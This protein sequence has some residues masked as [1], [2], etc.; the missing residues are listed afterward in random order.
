MKMPYHKELI[1]PLF[2]ALKQLGGSGTVDEIYEKVIENEKIPEKILSVMQVDGGNQTKVAYN[3]AWARTKLKNCGIITNPSRALWVI[4][5]EY[6]NTDSAE[7]MKIADSFHYTKNKDPENKTNTVIKNDLLEEYKPWEERLQEILLEINPYSFEVL[8]QRMLRECGLTQVEVTKKSGDGGIDG[9]GTLKLNGIIGF[10]LAFQCKRYKNS[11]SSSEIRD[12]RGSMTA[13]TEKGL[14]ITTGSFTQ[15]ARREANNP[16]KQIID[17]MDGTDLRNKLAE[18]KIG[19]KP[20]TSY[21]ID[22]QFFN[23]YKNKETQ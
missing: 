10:K 19:L 18:L 5:N 1:K 12:F 13:D 15:D 2:D 7:V 8:M 9:Y 4:N 6:L 20:I 3:L 11:V 14:F 17:L 21:E 23:A 16:G 22:E